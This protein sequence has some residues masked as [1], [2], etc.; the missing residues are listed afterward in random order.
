MDE[1]FAEGEQQSRERDNAPSPRVGGTLP[2]P[3]PRG[4]G[5]PP[6][7]RTPAPAVDEATT[8]SKTEAEEQEREEIGRTEAAGE[9][10]ADEAVEES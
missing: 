3:P 8:E 2:P 1:Y 4:A 5:V 7:A 10:K 6:P 9:A